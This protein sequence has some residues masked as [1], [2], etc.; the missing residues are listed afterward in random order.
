MMHAHTLVTAGWVRHAPRCAARGCRDSD[1]P[2][3][4]ASTSMSRPS[5][6]TRCAKR[7]NGVSSTEHALVDVEAVVRR[8]RVALASV[9][10]AGVLSLSPISFFA[11]APS[12]AEPTVQ[13]ETSEVRSGQDTS[14]DSQTKTTDE[15]SVWASGGAPLPLSASAPLPSEVKALEKAA[16][17]LGKASATVGGEKQ[18]KESRGERTAGRLK[19][20]NELRVELDLKELE[21]RQKTQELL[22]TEQTGAVLQEELELARRLNG[23]LKSELERVTEESKL[24]IGL[25]AQI[26]GPF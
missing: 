21:V 15:S 19:E 11:T 8:T 12:F 13:T 20:L 17:T 23:I 18:Q 22:R 14:A 9:F 26:G 6:S 3:R 2:R 5:T 7:V 4:V 25:C 16:L 1:T 10:A 24:S